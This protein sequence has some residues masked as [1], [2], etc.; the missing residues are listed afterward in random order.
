MM[1][2]AFESF[3]HLTFPSSI[4][5]ADTRLF[6]LLFISDYHDGGNDNDNDD[7]NDDGGED[8]DDGKKK[9]QNAV[10]FFIL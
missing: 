2:R 5:R 8:N 4:H 1:R 9:H 3:V 6:P 10:E 7:N